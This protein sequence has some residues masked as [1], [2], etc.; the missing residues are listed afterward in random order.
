MLDLCVNIP[1][2]ENCFTWKVNVNARCVFSFLLFILSLFFFFHFFFVGIDVLCAMFGHLVKVNTLNNCLTRFKIFPWV[3]YETKYISCVY[4]IDWVHLTNSCGFFLIFCILLLLLSFS[5]QY[6]VN[7]CFSFYFYMYSLLSSFFFFIH[8][9][10]LCVHYTL[11]LI[12]F[13]L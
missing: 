4:I 9:P 1:F 7:L 3:V 11:L 6:F 5:F 12:L 10:K 2:T 13:E 8:R